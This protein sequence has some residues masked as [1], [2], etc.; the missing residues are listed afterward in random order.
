VHGPKT[1]RTKRHVQPSPQQPPVQIVGLGEGCL[2][3]S[4]RRFGRGRGATCTMLPPRRRYVRGSL[5]VTPSREPESASAPA[6]SDPTTTSAASDPK[7]SAARL[8][9][10]PTGR[11]S[12]GGK[13]GRSESPASKRAGH[14]TALSPV[15]SYGAAL[16]AQIRLLALTAALAGCGCGEQ[17]LDWAAFRAFFRRDAQRLRVVSSPPP[18][19]PL[20]LGAADPS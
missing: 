10:S 17:P 11:R 8:S 5:V 3:R 4:V 20:L 15:G 19:S 16:V 1:A 6:S 13:A 9:K 2:S 7:P 14:G 18:A 12:R